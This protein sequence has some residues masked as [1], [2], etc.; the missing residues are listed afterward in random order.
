VKLKFNPFQPNQ[1]VA[2]GMFTGRVEELRTIER[3]LFQTRHSNPQHFLVEGE[4]GIGKSSL[5]FLVSAIA[6]GRFE[7]LQAS[8]PLNFV[9]V[10]IDLAGV[11]T[12]RDI[13]R[14][15]AKQLREV[16]AEKEGVKEKASALWAF[17]QK[18]ELM[19]VRYKAE[20]AKPAEDILDELVQAVARTVRECGPAIDG[21][22]VLIDE[23]DAPPEAADLGQFVKFFTERLARRS[24]DTV[25]LGLS[26]LP[27]TI[28]KLR[29]SHASAPRVF[30]VMRLD[31][32]E[33]GERREVVNRGLAL[34]RQRNGAATTIDPDAMDY[35]CEL[36]EGYPHFVQQFAYSAF[37]EN[38]DEV[39]DITDVVEGAYKENGALAQLG[40]K[41]FHEMYYGKVPSTEYRRVLS[42]MARHGD[43]WVMRKTLAAESGV[44]ETTLN[45]A[46]NMLRSKDVIL[47]DETRQGHYRLPTK[48][49][50]AWI[51]ATRSVKQKSEGESA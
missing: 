30:E 18:W 22:F 3:C 5:L 10:S 38:A 34:A 23:A 28:A 46:L 35:L 36:S 11:L 39:I 14:T 2:P 45:N 21:L 37:E 29:A 9:T 6:S 13:I 48:S 24:C 17:I 44:K 27:S 26:G 15:V 19:G 42:A 41:Y 4:R 32:L 1:M 12:Q 20:P 31:P 40:A 43:S 33:P 47:T 25:L 49:F 8:C 50:A 16:L 51:N 7:P